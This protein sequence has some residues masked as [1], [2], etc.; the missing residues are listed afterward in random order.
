ME[1]YKFGIYRCKIIGECK[2]FVFNKNNYYTHVDLEV[3][4]TCGLNVELVIDDQPNF[5]YY[6]KSCL[7]SGYHLFKQ[8]ISML[9]DVKK[10]YPDCKITKIILTWIS[11]ILGERHTKKHVL[12]ITDDFD[13]SSY[14]NL[15]M[16]QIDNNTTELNLIQYKG[17]DTS[18]VIFKH[19]YARCSPFLTSYGR[20]EILNQIG[21]S[22]LK[23][24][25]RIQTDGWILSSEPDYI[26]GDEMGQIKFEGFYRK[27]RINNVNSIT[28]LDDGSMICGKNT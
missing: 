23:N 15:I 5:L 8:A 3:A 20:R 27:I 26:F 18:D 11:G 19:D 14:D 17:I 24:V 2:Y 28:N 12:K 13:F 1:F 16:T 25:V 10:K 7:T 4:K 6:D 21:K 9:Y 22:N